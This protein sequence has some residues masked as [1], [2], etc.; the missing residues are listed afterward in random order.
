MF[1]Y[2]RT[3]IGWWELIKRTAY[4]TYEDDCLGLAAQLAYYFILALFP[5]L[6]FLIALASFFPIDQVTDEVMRGLA[7]VAPPDVVTLITT[8]MERIAESDRSE[9]HT[10]ELQSRRDVVC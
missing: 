5:A 3:S 8:Q 1:A 9:E 4:E 7:N 6:L 10:S 2:F